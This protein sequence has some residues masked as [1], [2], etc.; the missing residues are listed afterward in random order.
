MI[1]ISNILKNIL[2]TSHNSLTWQWASR[3]ELQPHGRSAWTSWVVSFSDQ[4]APWSTKKPN[5]ITQPTQLAIPS[6]LSHQRS[7]GALSFVL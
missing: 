4:G 7:N 5:P 1:C 2:I 3:L 6:K